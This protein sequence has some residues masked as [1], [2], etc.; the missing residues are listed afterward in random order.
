MVTIG[1]GIYLGA[2]C[3]DAGL[4]VIA[5]CTQAILETENVR[6]ACCSRLG[7]CTVRTHTHTPCTHFTGGSQV[8]SAPVNRHRWLTKCACQS[9][10]KTHTAKPTWPSQA[11]MQTNLGYAG[12]LK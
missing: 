8:V 6:Y 9:A 4:T 1:N 5:G 7:L 3:Y 11:L 2:A 12:P 10:A